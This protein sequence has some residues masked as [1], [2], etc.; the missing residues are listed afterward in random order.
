[1]QDLIRML[2]A[3][4]K[5][6]L[7]ALR[8]VTAAILTYHGWMVVTG[9]GGGLFSKEV[10]PLPDGLHMITAFLELGGGFLLLLGLFCRY[11]GVLFTLVFLMV[12][13][14]AWIAEGLGFAGAQYPLLLLACAMLI[15]ANGGGS[16]SLD[17]ALRRWDA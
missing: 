8:I 3:Q 7:S 1:M 2:A 9:E 10:F 16:L 17:R 11:L 13:Y 4:G 15:A 6:A 14:T 5:L 12:L